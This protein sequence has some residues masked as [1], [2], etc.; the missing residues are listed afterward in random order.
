MRALLVI[1]ACGA[2]L[3]GCGGDDGGSGSGPL[4]KAEYEERFREVVEESGNSERLSPPAGASPEQQ[5]DALKEGLD[6]L[7]EMTTG[8]DELEP[9]SEIRRG[10]DLYVEAL[11][12]IAGELERFETALRSGDSEEVRRLVEGGAGESFAK[13]ETVRKLQQ[14]RD[15]FQKNGYDLGELSTATP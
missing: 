14:A 3:A 9:P 5:A 15:E 11:K 8:L 4:S 2:L 10:H 12:E 1:A 7:R 13:P 6:R